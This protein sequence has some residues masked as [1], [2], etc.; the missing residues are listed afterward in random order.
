MKS[1]PSKVINILRKLCNHPE[2]LDLPNNLQWSENLIPEGFCGTG[3]SARDR[4]R[5]QGVRYDWGGKPVVPEQFLHRI[6]TE[7]NDKIVLISNYAQTLD[8]FEKLCR[9]KKYDFFRPDSTMTIN[10]RQKLVDRF[11]DPE[12]KEFIFLLGGKAGGCGIDLISANQL[13]LFDPDWNPAAGQQALA[14]VWCGSQKK[15]CFVYRFIP[16]ELSKRRSSNARSINEPY[17]PLS[18]TREKTP[19][20]ISPRTPS[21]SSSS[22][23]RTS[24]ANLATLSNTN[25]ARTGDRL[26]NLPHCCTET[27]A[28]GTTL[29]TRS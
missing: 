8:L 9:A 10:K 21:D 23:T 5:N 18:W 24:Y 17:H 14:R 1:Q 7:T 19:S 13:I 25:D 28:L 26:S 12:E 22:L 15:E 29:L 27:L 4:G 11:N 20:G 16:P 2:L 6:Q 3:G